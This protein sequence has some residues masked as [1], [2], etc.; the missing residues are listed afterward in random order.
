MTRQ[1]FSPS[2]DMSCALSRQLMTV[3]APGC[4]P[5]VEPARRVFLNTDLGNPASNAIYQRIGFRRGLD[6]AHIDLEPTP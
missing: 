2:R 5:A 6:L 4:D 3:G 1:N